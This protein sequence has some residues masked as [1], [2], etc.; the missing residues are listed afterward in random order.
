MAARHE[1]DPTYKVV[2]F[3]FVIYAIK[4]IRCPIEMESYAYRKNLLRFRYDVLDID[5]SHT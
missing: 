1:S 2:R 4:K 3:F 5:T